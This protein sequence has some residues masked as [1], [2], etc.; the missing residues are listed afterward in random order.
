LNAPFRSVLAAGADAFIGIVRFR[1][2]PEDVPVST[3]LLAA[4]LA[5]GMVLRGATLALL[6]QAERPS[7]VPAIALAMGATLLFTWLAVRIAGRPERFMQT[8][9]AVFGAQLVLAP[10]LLATGWFF[11]T[12][13]GDPAWQMPAIM[14]RLAVEVWV[15]VI[16]ARIIRSATGWPLAACVGLAIAAELLAWL[17][18]SA[19]Y[20]EPIG[21]GTGTAPAA[22]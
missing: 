8:A 11:L 21:T 5:G 20:P 6:P 12:Y 10:A 3:A 9:T 2:G 16:T 7:L 17:A 22:D 4:T 14:L 1:K 15:L 13:G 18:I 19:V